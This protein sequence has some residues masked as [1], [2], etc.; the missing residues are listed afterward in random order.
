MK[1]IN[2]NTATIAILTYGKNRPQGN[3]SKGYI[4]DLAFNKIVLYGG[5]IPFLTLGTPIW[6]QK[7]IRYL[8]ALISLNN[9]EKIEKLQE[10][11]LKYLL[12][13]YNVNCGLAE[14]LNT[15][16]SVAPVF[17]K[18]NIPIISNVLG[19][20]INDSRFYKL[21]Y[22][23]YKDLAKYQSFTLPVAKDMIPKLIELGFNDSSIIYSPIGPSDDFF[24]L[25]PNY[26]SEYFVFIGRFTETKNPFNLIK[27]FSKVVEKYSEA[28]LI[29]A[30]DGELKLEVIELIKS[31]NLFDNIILPGWISKDEQKRFYEQ[32]F[33]Y[34]QHSMVSSTG[35]REGT[36]VSILEASAAGLPIISTLHAGIPDVIIQNKT[37]FLVKENDVDM[38]AN[39]MLQLY[40]NRELAKKMGQFGK[41]IVNENFSLQ[42]HLNI[43]E[44]VI[45]SAISINPHNAF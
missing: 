12:K 36:P 26:K 25:K 11:R 23:K 3:F 39:F 6:K 42:I 19:Y 38:M 15:G 21:F 14:F 1:N 33:C 22:K 8:I 16:A 40:E 7:L 35:D 20:E 2:K 41:E 32:S 28:K 10:K 44:N 37:G 45:N 31:L 43:V 29:M 27:A 13:K 30:G 4:E 9:K 18:L 24:E 5:L 17:K 34:V